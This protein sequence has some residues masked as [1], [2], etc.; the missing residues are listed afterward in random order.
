MR[1]EKTTKNKTEKNKSP[2]KNKKRTKH[3]N[4]RKKVFIECEP[5]ADEE[6]GA[7]LINEELEQQ[8][9]ESKAYDLIFHIKK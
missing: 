1:K 9:L 8:V 7:E 3:E 4:A 2:V 6:I 5:P